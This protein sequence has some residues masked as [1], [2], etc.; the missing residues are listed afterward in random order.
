[1]TTNKP[2]ARTNL[3][4][5]NNPGVGAAGSN[6]R[7]MSNR[8]GAPA[9]VAI[10]NAYEGAVSKGALNHTVVHEAGGDG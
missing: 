5:T 7:R 10:T 6:A 8:R 9:G 3:R 4:G 1:M 2:R